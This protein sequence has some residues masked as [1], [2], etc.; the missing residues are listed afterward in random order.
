MK[1]FGWPES[2]IEGVIETR[3]SM[4]RAELIIK[5][6]A[7]HPSKTLA[8]IEEEADKLEDIFKLG[9]RE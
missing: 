2:K 4:V 3:W 1:C 6:H 8:Q 5:Y 9:M 7:E